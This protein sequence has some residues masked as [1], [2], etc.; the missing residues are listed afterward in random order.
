VIE[1]KSMFR[2]H[3]PAAASK[4]RVR[5]QQLAFTLIEVLIAIVIVGILTAI[6]LPQYNVFVQRSRIVDAHS[7]LNDLRIRMEQF[8]QDQRQY[9]TAGACGVAVPVSPSF[10]FTCV[11]AGNPAMSYVATATGT[12]P[13]AGFG[14]NVTVDPTL[15]GVGTLRTTVTVP[16]SW[17]P[18]PVPNTCWQVRK[19]GYCS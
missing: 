17:A 3:F 15:G 14:Y 6:A 5:R 12:G 9:N 11:P 16:G 8:F 7:G 1:E 4:R 10:T 2:V 18:L 13:M 19:G